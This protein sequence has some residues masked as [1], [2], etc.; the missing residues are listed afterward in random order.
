MQFN[1]DETFWDD[2]LTY[3]DSGCVIPVLGQGAITYGDSDQPFYPWLARRLAE[4]LRV[5]VLE[6]APAPSLNDIVCRHLLAGGGSNLVYLRLSQ[7]LV[8]ECPEP[9]PALR[10]FAEMEPFRLF[11]TTTFDPLLVRALNTARFGGQPRTTAGAFAPS[12]DDHVAD[13]PARLKD[14]QGPHVHHLLGQVSPKP[15]YVVWEEDALEFVCGLQ[16]RLE[17]LEYLARDLHEHSLLVL[18]LHFSD[19]LVRFFLR[20]A[21]QRR[22]SE[23]TDHVQYLAEGP[24]DA[25]PESMVLFF[26]GLMKTV[27]VIPTTP[28]SFI[29][30]LAR[31]WRERHPAQAGADLRFVPLPERAIEWGDIFISYAREDEAAA[32]QIKAGLERVG[33]RVWVDRERLKP[34]AHWH[35]HLEDAVKHQCG[36][37]IS[38][39][40]ETTEATP[41]AYYHLERNWAADRLSRFSEGE[42]FYFPVVIDDS[43]LLSVREPRVVR[44][45]QAA[46]IAGGIVDD[47]FAARIFALQQQRLAAPH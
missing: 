46:R 1:P 18:G 38:I 3:V 27:T 14:L 31:R 6:D 16:R 23:I 20:T 7:I 30:E 32:L 15:D 2:L 17:K 26:G 24:R 44:Q 25:L 19:W 39:I 28:A 22:L 42:V 40:S 11:L 47:G 13:L 8:A 37:F 43:Q 41:E 12:A 21:K 5:S 35:A 29:A 33:C 10:A 34:G 36:L 45:V 9:G 4:K